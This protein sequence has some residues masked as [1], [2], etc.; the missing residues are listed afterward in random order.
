MQSNP[1]MASLP[2]FRDFALKTMSLTQFTTLDAGAG[3]QHVKQLNEEDFVKIRLKHRGMANL[4]YFKGTETAILGHKVAYPIGLGTMPRQGQYHID[5]EVAA[6]EGAKE[7]GVVYTIDAARA[8]KPLQEILEASQGGLKLLRLCPYM[9]AE[10]K[11]QALKLAATHKDII[12]IVL[13]F[14]HNAKIDSLGTNIKANIPTAQ[15][16]LGDIQSIKEATKKPV[17]AQGILCAEDAST[18]TLSGADAIWVSNSGGRTLDATPSAISVLKG[19]TQAAKRA[20]PTVEV[21]VDGG[22]RRGIDVAKCVA[23]GA[24]MCFVG[25]PVAWA[26]HYGGK[27]GVYYMVGTIGD[28]FRTA[29]ILTDSMDVSKVTEARVIHQRPDNFAK[30]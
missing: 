22:V 19:I 13:D 30:L 27:E 26:L 24:T 15:W 1:K 6:A 3:A 16:R 17:I 29:M 5:G 9:S 7:A 21:Y 20:N 10:S 28:E 25:R 14:N 8:S 4:K 11:T 18:V 12:G 2:D 23:L